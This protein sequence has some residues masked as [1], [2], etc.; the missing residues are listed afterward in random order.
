[1]NLAIIQA[2]MG[3]SRLPSKVLLRLEGVPVLE[4]VI[5]RVSKSKKIDEIIVATTINKED[6]SIVEMCAS[7]GCR[8]FVGHANDVLDRYYQ[9][10][11]LLLPQNII[12]ITSDCP[13]IDPTIID[14]V[15]AEHHKNSND[16]TSNTILETFPDGLD[17]EVFSYKGLEIA[18]NEARLSSEREHVTPF[19]KKNP[20]RFKI[21]NVTNDIDLSGMRWTIDEPKDYKF[22]KEIF[23]RVYQKDQIFHL[24]DVLRVLAANPQLSSIN[25]DI[26]RNEGYL[27][28]L[29]NDKNS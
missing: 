21:Q 27:K 5:T 20:S 6:L 7:L 17:V 15:M 11:R 3:S 18:W 16:Y 13:M 29:Q 8:V 23:A 2:R 24:Q 4:H 28:S 14:T 25:N 10:A 12:R 1:M 26:L 19:I 22:L 9:A